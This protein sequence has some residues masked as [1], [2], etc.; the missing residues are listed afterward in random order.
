MFGSGILPRLASVK[1]GIKM[2][3]TVPGLGSSIV[4]SSLKTA[5]VKASGASPALYN[6]LCISSTTDRK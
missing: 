3:A 2:R 1:I 5:A 6:S 4:D